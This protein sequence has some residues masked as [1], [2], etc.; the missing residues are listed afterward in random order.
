MHLCYQNI[1]LVVSLI[2]DKPYLRLFDIYLGFSRS[3][4]TGVDTR[5]VIPWLRSV[6]QS[7]VSPS[8]KIQLF[9]LPED[10]ELC[11]EIEGMLLALNTTA[12]SLDIY[13]DVYHDERFTLF[14]KLY[15]AGIVTEM[16]ERW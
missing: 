10:S 8:L 11:A 2:V 13:L 1:P 16:R 7:L 6:C 9:E 3:Q 5:D 12:M 15:E 14:P 4:D